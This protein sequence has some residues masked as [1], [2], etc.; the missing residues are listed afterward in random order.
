MNNV[1]SEKQL[2]SCDREKLIGYR[3]WLKGFYFSVYCNQID[4]FKLKLNFMDY[5]IC[6]VHIYTG[7]YTAKSGIENH[8]N[9]GLKIKY[10]NTLYLMKAK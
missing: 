9:V 2:I 5:F 4:S 1:T 3:K 8:P 6:F 7:V 10:V